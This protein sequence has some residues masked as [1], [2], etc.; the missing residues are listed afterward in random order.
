MT[1]TGDVDE[2]TTT[3][4][5]ELEC[6]RMGPEL[7]RSDFFSIGCVKGRDPAAA[8]AH[9]NSLR[10][11]IV[12]HVVGVILKIDFTEQLKILAIIDVAHPTAIVGDKQSTGDISDALG[13]SQTADGV[14][15]RALMQ[16]NHLDGVVPERA[17][18][19]SFARII[20]SE[21]I[22]PPIDSRQRNRLLQLQ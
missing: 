19:Q 13:R 9:I 21:M 3:L 5:L 20:E 4:F 1:S 14:N 22:D 17:N 10:R 12:A 2:N 11:G 18:K 6:F 16:I 15:P 8:K 7:D